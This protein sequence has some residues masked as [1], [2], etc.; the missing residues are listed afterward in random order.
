[1]PDIINSF[2]VSMAAAALLPF[3][4]FLAYG[5]MSIPDLRS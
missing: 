4:F 2:K 3:S 1:V 5:V